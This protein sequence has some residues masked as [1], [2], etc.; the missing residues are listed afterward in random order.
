[1]RISSV[2]SSPRLSSV[3]SVS[4]RGQR[5]HGI[6]VQHHGIRRA[7]HDAH[8]D[9][10]LEAFQVLQIVRDDFRVGDFAIQAAAGFVRDVALKQAAPFAFA[11]FLRQARPTRGPPT[12]R[13]EARRCDAPPSSS[14]GWSRRSG[15]K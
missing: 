13:S 10:P 6:E 4:V 3:L 8:F 12:S 1:M 7:R 14:I 11:E 2:T 9:A 5:V 15:S